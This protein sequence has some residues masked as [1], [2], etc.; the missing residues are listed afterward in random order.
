MPNTATM[1]HVLTLAAISLAPAIIDAQS[2]GT[3]KYVGLSGV[4]AQQLF[5]G[6]PGKVYIVD[7][8][9]QSLFQDTIL[10]VRTQQC[11]SQW[12]SSLGN[13][14]CLPPEAMRMNKRVEAYNRKQVRHRL[15]H[16]SN[17]GHIIQFLLRGRNCP[18]ERNMAQCRRKPSHHLRGQLH[19][20]ESAI[21]PKPL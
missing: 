16:F 19:A 21:W 5:L 13:R 12:A 15:K 9:G 14:V 17:D 4:S 3:F 11:Y 8:T 20:C 1:L 18:W 6:R 7:K 2:P 10:M